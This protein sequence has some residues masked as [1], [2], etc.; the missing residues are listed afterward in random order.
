[1]FVYGFDLVMDLWVVVLSLTC[2]LDCF[3]LIG[4]VFLGECCLYGVFWCLFGC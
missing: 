1:M 3:D 4:L 2:L